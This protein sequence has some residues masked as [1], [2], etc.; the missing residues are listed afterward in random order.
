MKSSKSMF[1]TKYNDETHGKSR[2]TI[3]ALQ[4]KL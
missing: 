2:R 1:N 3:R 4:C